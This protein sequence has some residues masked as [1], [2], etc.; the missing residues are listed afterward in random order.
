MSHAAFEL[1]SG[2]S[3]SMP[4]GFEQ[5][6]MIHRHTAEGVAGTHFGNGAFIAVQTAIVA[7]LHEERPIAEAIAAFDTFGAP[8]AQSL[9]DHVFEIGVFHERSFDRGGRAQL[10]F[11]A[12]VQIVRLG[13]EVTRA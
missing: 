8:D 7:H 1:N 12:G 2:R 6:R 11:G 9:V 10:I 4:R 5:V 13:H 3:Y